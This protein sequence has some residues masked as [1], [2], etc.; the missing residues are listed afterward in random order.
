MNNKQKNI[1]LGVLI[2]GVISMTIAFAAYSTRLNI[3]GTAKASSFNWQIVIDD[4]TRDTNVSSLV[5]GSTNTAEQITA[6]TPANDTTSVSGLSVAFHK[7]GDV[8]KY[9]FNIENKGNIDAEL[10]SWHLNTGNEITCTSNNNAVTCP[11]IT[12]EVKCGDTD[13]AVGDALNAGGSIA[14]TYKVGLNEVNGTNGYTSDAITI[15]GLGVR[16]TYKE[17]ASQGGNTPVV[18]NDYICKRATTLNTATCEQ[19]G[20]CAASG[21]VGNGNQ[22]E[23]GV[24]GTGNSL[25][26]GEALDCKVSTSGWYTE[27]FYYIT[28]L[29]SNS[30][31]AVLLY[32]QDTS[33]GNV[34]Y[35]SNNRNYNGPVTAVSSLPTTSTW[36]NISLSS[37]SRQLYSWDSSNPDVYNTTTTNNGN[38]TLG[39]FNY[40]GYAGRLLTVK[41]LKAACPS[42]STSNGSLSSCS[43]LIEN[44]KYDNSSNTNYG[45]WLETPHASNS[46]RVWGVLGNGRVFNHSGASSS[47]LHG[48]RPAIE[49]PKSKI[50]LQ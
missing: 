17:K 40:S 19:S 8:V 2:V 39:T 45:Y 7:P 29:E 31:Y 14:C 9:N 30:D 28:D 18:Q 32:S 49:V 33:S 46:S 6:G 12:F 21:D 47:N 35:D 15:S 10:D 50:Q 27:R 3:N 38:K 34:A 25:T 44:T 16:F 23:Y 41:E 1:L 13:P 26:A 20:G 4:W 11:S 24:I 5:S 48:A 22:I 37:T 43:Y 42:A 36:D